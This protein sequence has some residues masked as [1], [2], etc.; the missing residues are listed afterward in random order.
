MSPELIIGE[1]LARLAV[2]RGGRIDAMQ[3][4]VYLDGLLDLPPDL[5]QRACLDIGKRPRVEFDSIL[6][7]VG[8]IRA[9]VET[10]R[11]TDVETD[12]RRLLGSAPKN[13]GDEPTFYCLDCHDEPNGWRIY[14]CRGVGEVAKRGD[15]DYSPCGRTKTHTPHAFAELCACL[16]HNP[17]IA[18][19]KEQMRKAR[20]KFNE[21]RR[22]AA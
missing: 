10:V 15:G 1:A 3:S 11:R 21:K 22:G 9:E 14:Q 20:Q 12:A 16:P 2:A 4:D 17:V 8:E 19:A 5:V 18:R 13:R 7:S 6:P